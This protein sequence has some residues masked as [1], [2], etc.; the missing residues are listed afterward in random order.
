MR[1]WTAKV[2][3]IRGKVFKIKKLG[4]ARDSMVNRPL[5]PGKAALEIYI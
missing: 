5:H 3:K 4:D 2:R 1:E